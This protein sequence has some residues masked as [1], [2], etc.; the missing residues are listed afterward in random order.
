MFFQQE[1]GWFFRN[2]HRHAFPLG[3]HH[4]LRLALSLEHPSIRRFR[5]LPMLPSWPPPA[6]RGP[7]AFIVQTLSSA[8]VQFLGATS[9][10]IAGE[11][12]AV[13]RIQAYGVLAFHGLVEHRGHGEVIFAG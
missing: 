12:K 8:L 9:L 11:F 2:Q 10:K 1:Y 6:I 5:F 4:Q 13:V 7:P 3:E